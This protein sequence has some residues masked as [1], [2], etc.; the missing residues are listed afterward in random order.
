MALEHHKEEEEHWSD[1]SL[2]SEGE[3]EEGEEVGVVRGIQG[4]GLCHCGWE[5]ELGEQGDTDIEE[6]V[7]E[8]EMLL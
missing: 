3:E 1:D 5:Q 4:E 7:R 8:T 6:G 2:E